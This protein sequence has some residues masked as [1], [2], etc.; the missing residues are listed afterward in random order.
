MNNLLLLVARILLSVMFIMAGFQKFGDLAGTAGYISS[1]G[2]PA[3]S[4]LAPLSGALEVLAGL[5]VLVGFQTRIA[6]WLL[7]AFCVVTALFFHFAPADMMQMLMFTKNMAIAG[8]FLAL[9]VAGA[10]AWSVDG[11]RRG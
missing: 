7:A 4:L 5:A 1:V 11:R 10:G 3:G 9:S 2:L 6:A 8:G